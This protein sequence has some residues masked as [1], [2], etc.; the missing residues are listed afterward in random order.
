MRAT[1]LHNATPPSPAGHAETIRNDDRSSPAAHSANTPQVEAP[2]DE[3]AGGDALSPFT[4]L[5]NP[6]RAMLI[7]A[8]P[9]APSQARACHASKPVSSDPPS[10]PPVSPSPPVTFPYA[11]R[12]GQLPRWSCFHANFVTAWASNARASNDPK[13]SHALSAEASEGHNTPV[14]SLIPCSLHP[15]ASFMVVE[16]HCFRGGVN[17]LSRLLRQRI[18]HNKMFRLSSPDTSA[19][20]LSSSTPLH[21]FPRYVLE[22][23]RDPDELAMWN[24]PLREPRR[25]RPYNPA[26]VRCSTCTSR[27]GEQL[28]GC[29]NPAHEKRHCHRNK[30]CKLC[31]SPGYAPFEC[32]FPHSNRQ[33]TQRCRVGAKHVHVNDNDKCPWTKTIDSE[34]TPRITVSPSPPTTLISTKLPTLSLTPTG[35]IATIHAAT[36]RPSMSSLG[37]QP[38]LPSHLPLEYQHWQAHSVLIMRPLPDS[39]YDN[40]T[41]AR[42]EQ[43]NA[44]R[45]I[46]LS[47]TLVETNHEHLL[48]SEDQS[49][50]LHAL[51]QSQVKQS[52]MLPVLP[53]PLHT[54]PS[55]TRMTASFQPTVSWSSIVPTLSRTTDRIAQHGAVPSRSNPREVQLTH[56]I[57]TPLVP[58]PRRLTWDGLNRDS[59]SYQTHGP[60]LTALHTDPSP[61]PTQRDTS[62][63]SHIADPSASQRSTSAHFHRSR[64]RF[65]G[66]LI[67]PRR[68]KSP[69]ALTLVPHILHPG[70][71]V[72]GNVY[73]NIDDYG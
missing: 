29:S 17:S 25:F 57:L 5:R 42:T 54:L 64:P 70:Q 52:A 11:P 73:P 19:A 56:S 68:G 18:Q 4:P 39:P 60:A 69:P 6:A 62:Q 35:L 9:T 43:R 55:D 22:L 41:H 28:C 59:D 46:V 48:S 45:R 27:A 49:S 24:E 34:A 40:S 10:P 67:V 12:H 71:L 65:P 1:H 21:I 30:R 72:R 36:L 53:P 13:T 7:A 38:P 14:D 66:P 32:L 47:D 63:V 15:D 33:A 58:Y 8:P 50:L 51:V 3:P 16:D 61:H 26:A 31:N 23:S 37:D 44:W 2:A 20:P